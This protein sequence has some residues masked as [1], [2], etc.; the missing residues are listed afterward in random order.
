MRSITEVEVV[1]RD[2]TAAF[3]NKLRERQLEWK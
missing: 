2:F 1:M 3:L